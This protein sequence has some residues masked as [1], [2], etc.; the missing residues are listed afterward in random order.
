MSGT[1]N[2]CASLVYLA[3]LL[4][5]APACA[6][7]GLFFGDLPTV[8]TVSRL[9][10]PQ[11]EAPG[12]VTVIDHEMIVASGARDLSDLLRLV[13]GFQVTSR[14]NEPA[15]VSYHGLGD[16]D[17]SPR[18]QVLIDGR[19]QYSPLFR[20]GVNWDVLPVAL[21][22][23]DHIEVI[24]GSNSA[25]Y[26]SNAFLGVV[27]IITLDAS[28]TRGLAISASQG[29]G[30][31]AERSVRWGGRIGQADVRMTVQQRSD[32]GWDRQPDQDTTT[33]DWNDGQRLR[34]FDLRG[35]LPVGD[36][37]SLQFGLGG[38]GNRLGVG[39]PTEDLN[40]DRDQTESS[41]YLQLTWRHVINDD[42]ETR[43]AYYHVED[44]I[45]DDYYDTLAFAPGVTLGFDAQR[46]G[47]STRDDLEFQHTLALPEHASR[48]VWGMEGRWDSVVFPLYYG[49]DAAQHR[50]VERLFG[51]F[52]WRPQPLWIVNTGA[53]LE[54]DSGSGSTLAPRF[55]INRHLD[56]A[57][58]LRFV[59]SRAYRSPST[60]QLIGNYRISPSTING[61]PVSV[62]SYYQYKFLGNA[63]LRPERVDAIEIGYH[64]DWRALRSNLDV[65]LYREQVHDRLLSVD[66]LLPDGYCNV[67][68]GNTVLCQQPVKYTVNGQDVDLHGIEYQWQWQPFDG[69]RL[70][71]SQAFEYLHAHLQT[72]ASTDSASNLARLNEQTEQSA[73]QRSDTVMW[74]QQLGSG[75]SYSLVYYRIGTI[76]WTQNSENGSYQRID[77]RLAYAFRVGGKRAEAAFT[78]Q[79]LDGTHDEFRTNRPVR[80]RGWLTLS[81]EL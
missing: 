39:D 60:S 28:Q 50:D 75:V 34:L 10:Q 44:R 17:Y 9:A 29:N 62:G 19:S 70:I 71:V 51:S 63:D 65:R 26:G 25:A 80:E 77:G 72:F 15:R 74:M 55:G 68:P 31:I 45:D 23:I 6:D 40:P 18:V 46:S 64:G 59:V 33:T 14:N 3:T 61:A 37:D 4:P 54:H 2:P 81:L 56:E 16:D 67:Y 30:G 66:T 1:W 20:G 48:L 8:L 36:A 47:H 78:L 57:Q 27:N 52:E 32:S 53:S 11:S 76:Q 7:D 24:R 5:A 58:T 35:D 69:S 79:S 41:R 38:A 42:S 13:P 49:S 12:S 43:L 73:P 21:A 22:D